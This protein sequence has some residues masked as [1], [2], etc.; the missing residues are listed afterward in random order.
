[1]M[2]IERYDSHPERIDG[3]VFAEE[4][5]AIS[6]GSYQVFADVV[7]KDGFPWTPTLLNFAGVRG[8]VATPRALDIARLLTFPSRG[9]N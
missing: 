9:L 8:R 2:V 5:P 4:L 1:M 3:G 6:A 7:D